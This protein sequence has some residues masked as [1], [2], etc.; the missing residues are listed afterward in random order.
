MR[1]DLDRQVK[2]RILQQKLQ[3]LKQQNCNEEGLDEDR[4][5]DYETFLANLGCEVNSKYKFFLQ[6]GSDDSHSI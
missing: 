5:F 4:A 1:D 2:K 3:V 6:F